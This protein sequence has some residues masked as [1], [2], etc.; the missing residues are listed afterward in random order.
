MENF[1]TVIALITAGTALA[2]GLVNIII[3]SLKDGD[4]SDL[5]FGI[6]CLCMFVFFM[7]PPVGFILEDKAPYTLQMDIKRFFNFAFAALLPWFV[8]LYTGSRKKIM[9]IVI[10]VFT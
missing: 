6:M 8:L 2:I 4:T 5:V 1:Y 9:P 3:G 10:D 7:L